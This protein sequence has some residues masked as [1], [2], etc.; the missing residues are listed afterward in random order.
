MTSDVYC[1]VREEDVRYKINSSFSVNRRVTDVALFV[2]QWLM[3]RN[4]DGQLCYWLHVA[5]DEE[6]LRCRIQD[7]PA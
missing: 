1:T 7:T 2:C 5:E 3:L 4:N 6:V